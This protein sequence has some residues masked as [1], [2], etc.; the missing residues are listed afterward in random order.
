MISAE[1]IKGVQEL[2][3]E[4]GVQQRQD[5]RLGDFVAR[6]LGITSAQAEALLASL[7]DGAEVDQAVM[8]GGIDRNAVNEDLLV[9]LARVIGSAVGRAAGKK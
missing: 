5:E 7:H 8:A 9:H 3:V 1:V 4:R 6:G 2:L